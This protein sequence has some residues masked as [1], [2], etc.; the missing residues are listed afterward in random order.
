MESELP[1]AADPEHRNL[2]E[3]TIHKAPQLHAPGCSIYSRGVKTRHC[4]VF[5]PPLEAFLCTFTQHCFIVILVITWCLKKTHKHIFHGLVRVDVRIEAQNNIAR[6]YFYFLVNSTSR[7][8]G[9]PMA[10]AETL[11][12]SS[13]IKSRRSQ[14]YCGIE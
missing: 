3:Y 4:Q 8:C 9:C 6:R 2:L 13:S 10:M 5:K 11:I 1:G 14:M 7:P 12:S